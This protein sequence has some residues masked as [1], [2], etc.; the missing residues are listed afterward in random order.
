MI[1]KRSIGTGTSSMRAGLL[2]TASLAALLAVGCLCIV[3]AAAPDA[4]AGTY[5]VG[6]FE[7]EKHPSKDL[8]YLIRYSGSGGD[9]TIPGKVVLSGAECTVISIEDNAFD[10]CRTVA[11]VSIPEGITSIGTEA[12]SGC[13]EMAFFGCSSLKSVIIPS[14]VTD[15]GSSAFA[16][17]SSLEYVSHFGSAAVSESAFRECTSLSSVDISGNVESIRI[18]AFFCCSSLE[19]IDFPDSLKSIEMRAFFGCTSLKSIGFGTGPCPSEWKMSIRPTA[20]R[21]SSSR[22]TGRRRST[23]EP[24]SE[25][26]GEGTSRAA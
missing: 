26:S 16:Y 22:K 20:F 18:Y 11:S 17:C 23:S 3:T 13:G 7:F 10:G 1:G 8:A 15:I 12:F 21:R 9:V 4:D 2:L 6:D 5:A 14:S 25:S 19:S 24:I